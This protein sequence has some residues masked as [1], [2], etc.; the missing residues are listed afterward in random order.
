MDTWGRRG[1]AAAA[2]TGGQLGLSGTGA[3]NA[4]ATQEPVLREPRKPR[5][6]MELPVT[7]PA[8][9]YGAAPDHRQPGFGGQPGYGGPAP[10]HQGHPGY[11][12]QPYGAPRHSGPEF[13]APMAPRV[14]L[15]QGEP[16]RSFGEPARPAWSEPVP[17]GSDLLSDGSDGFLAGNVA[18][19]ATPPALDDSGSAIGALG[20]GEDPLG[21][22]FQPYGDLPAEPVRPSRHARPEA[23]ALFGERPAET[24]YSALRAEI[25]SLGVRP[26]GQDTTPV[27]AL[28]LAGPETGEG[29]GHIGHRTDASVHRAG[30]E[31]GTSALGSLDSSALFDSLSAP[32]R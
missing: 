32:R 26:V 12:G 27:R 7:T 22:G 10:A 21:I 5:D 6:S 3:W 8:A 23:D 17:H 24:H 1:F 9:G 20:H 2:I 19:L 25:D 4:V 28:R 31:S 18:A 13:G 14:P 11:P 15:G 29:L 30:V 16:H